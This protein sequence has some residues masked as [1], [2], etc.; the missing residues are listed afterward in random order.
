VRDA[1]R[2]LAE[3][4]RSA[5][6]NG[7]GGAPGLD[8]GR[9][10]A[11]SWLMAAAAI[12]VLNQLHE[13]LHEHHNLPPIVHWLRD[14]SLTVPLAAIAVLA[15]AL[16]VRARAGGSGRASSP[17]GAAPLIWAVLAALLFAVLSIPGNQLHGVLFGAEEESVGWLQDALTDGS[18][19]LAVSLVA[20]VPVALITG[21][22]WRAARSPHEPAQAPGPSLAAAAGHSASLAT[23]VS[24]NAGGDR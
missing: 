17:S 11:Y 14:A 16:V 13:G 2:D 1:D 7:A 6:A 24:T 15:A 18:I 5:R 9:V 23:A 21:P 19:A 8:A 12:W 22:P 4:A 10:V 3:A 20:L